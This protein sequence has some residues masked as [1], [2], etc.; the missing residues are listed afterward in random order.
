[1]PSPQC[2]HMLSA[3]AL[4]LLLSAGRALEEH[5]YV[6]VGPLH[7]P[8]RGKPNRDV[9]AQFQVRS[10]NERRTRTHLRQQRQKST[11]AHLPT[12]SGQHCQYCFHN[13][14]AAG[15]CSNHCNTTHGA[16][17]MQHT[18]WA[19]FSFISSWLSS[20]TVSSSSSGSGRTWNVVNVAHPPT[21]SL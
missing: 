17:Q 20:S 16:N 13:V 2:S 19:S 21:R 1:M 3:T 7:L 12:I 18:V 9:E 5:A 15:A 10:T 14:S 11:F 4:Q 6:L 8:Q